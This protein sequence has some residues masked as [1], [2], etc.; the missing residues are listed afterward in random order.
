[1]VFGRV[2]E[3]EDAVRGLVGHAHVSH[4]GAGHVSVSFTHKDVTNG[5]ARETAAVSILA[6]ALIE[7][8]FKARA[9]GK[10][11][12]GE[13]NIKEALRFWGLEPDLSPDWSHSRAVCMSTQLRM[14]KPEAVCD[15][16]PSMMD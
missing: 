6:S 8:D 16:P 1:M 12:K 9:T 3:L 11:S 13:G 7:Y 10:R 15:S 2:D 4:L 14:V 5:S